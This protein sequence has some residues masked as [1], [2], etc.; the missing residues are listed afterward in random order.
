MLVCS[1]AKTKLLIVGTKELRRT[2]LTNQNKVIKISVAGYDVEETSSERLLGLVINNSLTWDN[3]LHGNDEHK[4]LITKLSQRAGIIRKL[5][6]VMPK[7]RLI[8]FAEGLFFSLLNYCIEVYGNVWGLGGYDETVRHSTAFR[9][10]DNNKLQVLVN[11]VLRAMT[12]LD[13]DTPSALLASTSGQLSVH[14]RTAF[15]TLTSVHKSLKMKEPA[16]NYESF[17]NNFNDGQDVHHQANCKRIK[18]NLSLSRCGYYYRG[19][20][21]YNKLPVSL[22]NTPKLKDFK[23]NAKIWVKNNIP[24]RPP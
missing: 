19:S 20:R 13:N 24:L 21:L 15:F 23:K 3:H 14:Q 5:S 2:K 7:E 8:I 1:G 12:G 9:K 17:I 10:E 6:F 22:V 4:G 18:Y 16:Y 11:K